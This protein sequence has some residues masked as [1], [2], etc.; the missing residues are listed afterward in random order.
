MFMQQPVNVHAG[1][2]TLV[3][4]AGGEIFLECE[5]G[6]GEGTRTPLQE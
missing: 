5:V 2:V 3:H 4:R 6:K 1:P